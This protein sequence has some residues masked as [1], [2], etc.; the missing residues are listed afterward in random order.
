MS[1]LQAILMG[2]IQGAT[3]FL[4]V[5]SSGH[6]AIFKNIFGVETDTGILFDIL[7]HFGTLVAIFIVYWAD[8]KKLVIEGLKIVGDCCVNLVNFIKNKTSNEGKIYPYRKIVCTAY[9]KFVMLILVSTLT[10][11]VIAVP[12]DKAIGHAGDTLLIPGICL[13]ITSVILYF[14]DRLPAGKK[15]VAKATY[16][17]AIFVGLAQAVATLPGISRSGST[18]TA[19]M[20]CGYTRKF[21]VKYSFIM[22]IPAVLGAVILEIPDLFKASISG[23]DVVNYIVGMIVAGIVGY[24]CI[25]LCF[26]RSRKRILRDFPYIV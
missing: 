11:T 17:N 5:S 4:P 9:R 22:S 23:A 14:A 2:I 6:L 8:I 19:G 1:L 10:T 24:I 13:C 12:F 26:I 16:R 21:T 15:S 7:L 18:I 25:N 20:A 3:E